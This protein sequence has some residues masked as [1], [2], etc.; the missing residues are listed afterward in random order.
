MN[1]KKRCFS[2]IQP[3]GKITIGNYLGAIQNWISIQQQYDCLFC[4]ADLHSLTSDLNPAERQ[5]NIQYNIA[6]YIA[7]GL[8]PDKVIIFQQSK[9]PEHSELAWILSCFTQIGLLNKM[10]Q[11]KD[12]TEI[13][14]KTASLGL[15]SYP[16]LMAADIL[17]YNTKIVPVGEDQR[18]HIELT[19]DI[20]IAFNKKMKQDIFTIPS[21]SISHQAKRIMS[22]KNTANKMS[23]SDP[24]DLSRINMSDNEQLIRKKIRKAKTDDIENIYYNTITRPEVSNLINIYLCL[25]GLDIQTFTKN[26]QSVRHAEFKNA[27]SDTIIKQI[28]PINHKALEIMKDR[29]YLEDVL[30]NGTNKARTIAKINI[31]VIK[32]IIG[33]N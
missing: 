4:I 32:N 29:K 23:K 8:D 19:R 17:L 13:N 10:I 15:Y 5:K 21:I 28:C 16:V 1:N 25:T 26:F 6:L 11:F 12:K 24:S 14:K 7:S 30:S 2:G 18:Q 33:M 3:T 9:I 20:A 22:L 31:N 27:L